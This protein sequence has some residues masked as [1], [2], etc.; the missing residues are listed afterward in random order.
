MMVLKMTVLMYG[1][2]VDERF[3][4]QYSMECPMVVENLLLIYE[5]TTMVDYVVS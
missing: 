4:K 3:D 5:Y 2:E 1:L